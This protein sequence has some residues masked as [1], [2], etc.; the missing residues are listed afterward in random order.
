MWKIVSIA[1]IT[2][3]LC[4]SRNFHMHTVEAHQVAPIEHDEQNVKVGMRGAKL[5]SSVVDMYVPINRDLQEVRK[6]DDKNSCDKKGTC[7]PS[8]SPTDSPT[9]IPSATPTKYPTMTPTRSPTRSPTI[10]PRPSPGPTSA[11]SS[12]PT[13]S[14]SRFPTSPP[15]T[16]VNP[17]DSPS[18]SPSFAPSTIPTATPT[19]SMA[20]SESIFTTGADSSTGFLK[21]TC[22][23]PP[24]GGT[25]SSY[26]LDFLYLVCF[27]GTVDEATAQ[28]EVAALEPE[29]LLA[30]SRE[31]M[32]CSYLNA[33]N[34][35]D[36]VSI[37]TNDED[38]LQG[39]SGVDCWTFEG[40]ITTEV[41]FPTHRRSLQEESV[42]ALFSGAINKVYPELV[43]GKITS[44]TFEGFKEVELEGTETVEGTTLESSAG[45]AGAHSGNI[46]ADGGKDKGALGIV[47]IVVAGMCLLVMGA[48]LVKRARRRQE[49]YLKHLE[50]VGALDLDDATKDEISKRG[51]IVTYDEDSVDTFRNFEFPEPEHD[52]RTCKSVTCRICAEKSLPIFIAADTESLEQNIK[53]DL[54]APKFLPSGNRRT[55]PDTQDL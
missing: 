52:P 43:G 14:P 6:H 51:H 21:S 32:D 48:L 55:V 26:D 38:T 46:P 50:D 27:Q 41:Y 28:T 25:V 23:N 8:D 4:M 5:N 9:D 2:A 39:P 18:L 12:I 37:S 47:A 20:P 44:I 54:G 22:L 10:S 30:L 53:A 31:T 34:G 7:A 15:S 42:R 24:P 19:A 13:H 17:T 45:V 3:L 33:P 35:L 1:S 49:L 40:S 11:P 16:S 36:L 29:F